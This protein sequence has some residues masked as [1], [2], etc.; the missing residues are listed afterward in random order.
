MDFPVVGIHL[1]WF[2]WFVGRGLLLVQGRLIV[3][4]TIPGLC[5]WY[6]GADLYLVYSLVIEPSSNPLK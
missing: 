5:T 2:G 6:M 3:P 1:F 4:G